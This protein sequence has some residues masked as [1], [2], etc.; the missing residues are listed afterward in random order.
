MYNHI[1]SAANDQ[2]PNYLRFAEKAHFLPES[3]VGVY[4]SIVLEALKQDDY[5]TDSKCKEQKKL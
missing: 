4:F 1:D 2:T 5:A 3:V